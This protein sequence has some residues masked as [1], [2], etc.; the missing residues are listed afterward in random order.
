MMRFADHHCYLTFVG[1][2]AA[3]CECFVACGN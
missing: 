1:Y 3:D 2:V